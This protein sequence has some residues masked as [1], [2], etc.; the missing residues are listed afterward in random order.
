MQQK[1]GCIEDANGQKQQKKG[2]KQ[3][4][5]IKKILSFIILVTSWTNACSSIA[6]YFSPVCPPPPKVGCLSPEGTEG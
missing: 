2:Q 6:V 5:E 1:H 4:K 3:S